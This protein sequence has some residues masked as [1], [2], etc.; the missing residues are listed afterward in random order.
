MNR[1]AKWIKPE[2]TRLIEVQQCG[3]IAKLRKPNAPSKRVLGPEHEVSAGTIRIVWD[4]RETVLQRIICCES[5]SIICWIWK[6]Y[7]LQRLWSST[8]HCPRHRQPIT[9]LQCSNRSYKTYVWWNRDDRLRRFNETLTNWH[10]MSSVKK[11]C[12]CGKWPYTTFSNNKIWVT[13][14]FVKKNCTLNR[15]AYLKGCTLELDNIVVNT[16]GRRSYVFS[17][18]INQHAFPIAIT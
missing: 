4:I 12:I 10:W 5:V 2:A 15:H 16:I 17:K 13:L 7:W 8:Q 6:C 14:T 3:I 11:S 18:G 1:N 9:L